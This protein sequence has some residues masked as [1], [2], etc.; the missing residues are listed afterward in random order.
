[1]KK[2]FWTVLLS[3][4]AHSLLSQEVFNNNINDRAYLLELAKNVNDTG[5]INRR[6]K[7]LMVG[8]KMPDMLL[9]DLGKLINYQGSE[10][11]IS[12]FK[13]K[14]IVF[15]FWN[16]W[17]KPCIEGFPKM[18]QLQKELG[19]KI[20]IFLVN[21][22]ETEEMISQSNTKFK[23]P[24]LPIIAKH[25]NEKE[26]NYSLLAQPD[27]FPAT[28]SG[29]QVWIGP[30]GIVRLRGTSRNNYSQKMMDVLE[31]KDVFMSK[32]NGTAVFANKLVPYHDVVYNFKNN[33]VRQGSLITAFNMNYDP[34]TRPTIENLIDTVLKTRRSTYINQDILSLYLFAY[35]PFLKSFKENLLY[36][37][38]NNLGTI[39]TRHGLGL[40][41][42][43]ISEGID[44]SEYIYEL[45]DHFALP[46]DIALVNARKCYEQIAP[47]EITEEQFLE[48][49]RY[50]LNRF[51]GSKYG[52]E[53]IKE[54]RR[55]KCYVLTR[56]SSMDK[57]KAAPHAKQ[58]KRIID[59]G[60]TKALHLIGMLSDLGRI[61]CRDSKAIHDFFD[62]E[63][64]KRN[65]LFFLNETGWNKDKLIDI[66]IPPPESY[67][68]MSELG[69][70]LKKY[71]LAIKEEYR[72]LE[73]LVLKE[74][75]NRQ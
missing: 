5:Y 19:D 40:N 70:A 56:T 33:P 54:K 45:S 35:R 75:G 18:E 32:L 42:F 3:A 69:N 66:T 55:V 53:V 24:Q 7:G 6:S 72:E 57:V 48:N 41:S 22:A 73:F 1:M 50:D 61:G 29:Q 25:P 9:T 36:G 23:M 12:D 2:L 16:T 64:A 68:S 71:D 59:S 65:S 51:I 14:L 52:T 27:F 17:C 63:H 4:V 20:Q 44:T 30:D 34:E 62:Q 60:D 39:E 58:S 26:D 46:P 13:R 10:K 8:D 15:D 67:K 11:R 49:M 21:D 31:G 37:P 43:I 74:V 47:M 28:S 38:S